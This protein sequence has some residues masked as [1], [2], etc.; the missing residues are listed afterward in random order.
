ML[1]APR[2]RA[3]PSF[4]RQTN[5]PCSACHTGGFYPELNNYGRMFKLNGYIWSA[6]EDKAYETIPPVSAVQ[7]FSY[8]RTD[9]DQPGLTRRNG[10]LPTVAFGS[11]GNDNFSFPQQ[12]NFFLAGRFYGRLGGFIMGTYS[13]V[14]NKWATDNIDVRLTDVRTFGE[15]HTLLYGVT[16]NNGPTVQDAWNGRS[17][18][19]HQVGDDDGRR[20]NR[21]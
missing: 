11:D 9:K 7:S 13:G 19:G 18:Q 8:T 5:M 4:A 3:V 17:N 2:A 20:T 16:L 1:A 14:D 12:A 21:L 15:K 6:S 10:R